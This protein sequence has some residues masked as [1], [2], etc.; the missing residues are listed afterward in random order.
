MLSLRC[1]IILARLAVMVVSLADC[2]GS[3]GTV[4]PDRFLESPRAITPHAK[5]SVGMLICA[6]L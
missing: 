2:M 3:M 4:A 5:D 1:C 6:G